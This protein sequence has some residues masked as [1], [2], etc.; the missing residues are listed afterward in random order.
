MDSNFLKNLPRATKV[1]LLINIGLFIIAFL[2]PELTETFALHYFE[3]SLFMP[4]QLVSH[5]F[6]HGGLTHLLFNMYALVMFGSILERQLDTKRFC[7]LYFFSAIG[8]FLLHMI[9]I[10]YQL[11]DVPADIIAQIQTEGAEIISNGQNYKDAY[12][13]NMNIKYNQAMVGASGAIMGLL[14]SFAILFPNAELQ[15]IFIPVPIKAKFF[16]PIYMLIEL[17]LGVRD[18][19]WDNVAHFAHLGGAIF[20][21]LL[22]FYWLKNRR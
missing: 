1:L 10:W 13:G 21:G 16:M 22:M 11:S 7:I 5:I 8:A 9:I 6:M 18:F 2:L 3:S 15:L 12:L 17:F 14:I 4:H 20:G 19:Q